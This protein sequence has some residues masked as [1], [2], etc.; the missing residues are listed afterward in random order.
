[1]REQVLVV[2]DEAAVRELL[3]SQVTHMGYDAASAASGREALNKAARRPHPGLVLSDLHMPDFSGLELLGQLRRLDQNIQVV[4][5]TANDDL[6]T[7]R[8]CLREGAYDYLVK[9]YALEDLATTIERALERRRLKLEIEEYQRDLEKKVEA[10]TQE[11]LQTRDIALL[12]LAKL[13]ECRDDSTGFHLDRIQWYSRVLAEGL[14][15]GPYRELTTVDFVVKVAKSSQLHDIGKVAIPDRVLLKRGPLTA[16]EQEVMRSHTTRGGDTLRQVIERYRNPMTEGARFLRAAMEIAYFHHERWDGGGYPGGVG[17]S[18]IPLAARIVAVA[19][20]YDAITSERPY[21]PARDHREA[22][23]RIV[24]DRGHHFDPVVV[25]VFLS[26]ERQFDLI[27]R[28][29]TSMMNA[30]LAARRPLAPVKPTIV[31]H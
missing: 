26:R 7:V 24:E 25:D 31:R 12:T 11:V 10:K 1:M 4:M 2:D 9:P 30:E 28:Q 8:Q 19:D 27:R 29:M 3:V 22:V 6:N 15:H 5:V 13:A 17:G 18:A 20:A 23:Q 16:D 14:R 21:E